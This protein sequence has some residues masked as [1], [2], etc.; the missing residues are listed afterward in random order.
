MLSFIELM[1][2]ISPQQ[3]V[4]ELRDEIKVRQIERVNSLIAMV[5]ADCNE[6]L[7]NNWVKRKY[8]QFSG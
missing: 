2:R 5:S 8:F 1:R 7:G 3:E 4:K 6:F